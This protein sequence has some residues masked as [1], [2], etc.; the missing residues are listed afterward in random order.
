MGLRGS[1]TVPLTLEEC[2][3]PE[4][5]LLGKEGDGF[6]VAMTALDGGRIGVASQ[7]LGIG[8]AALDEGRR[9]AQE[10]Q[11][12]GKPL[13][14][15]QAIQFMLADCKV[16]LEAARLLTLRA[17]WLK[18]NKRPFTREAAMAKLYSSEAANRVCYRTLQVHG[19][20]GYTKEYAVERL[21]RDARVTTIYEG[22][23]EIQR[24]VIGRDLVRE[25]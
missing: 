6:K 11:A 24:L 3:V 17:A 5:A 15:L 25:D 12:F 10:R 20:Y 22:T 1:T 2:F 16:E 23:S 14:D 4:G 13:A 19:G 9:Y 8:L 7:A 18:E 21:T